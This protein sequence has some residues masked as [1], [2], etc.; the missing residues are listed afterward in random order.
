MPAANSKPAPNSGLALAIIGD[1]TASFSNP[2]CNNVA[3][4]LKD[5]QADR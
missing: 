5:V 1:N 2:H 3:T 4:A